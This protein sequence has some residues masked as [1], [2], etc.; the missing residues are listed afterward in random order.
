QPV[1]WG[2][3][4]ARKAY[5]GETKKDNERVAARIDLRVA[6]YG[7][8]AEAKFAALGRDKQ[9]QATRAEAEQFFGYNHR[10]YQQVLTALETTPRKEKFAAYQVKFNKDGRVALKPNKL[11]GT[12]VLE[13]LA[14][15]EKEPVPDRSYA[16]YLADLDQKAEEIRAATARVDKLVG[17][18]AKQTLLLNGVRA[19]DGKEVS[20]GYYQLL[21]R[22]AELQRK[23]RDEL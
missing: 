23:L 14:A 12:P 18:A 3:K 4:E 21:D 15:K 13:P 5:A 1:D 11:W 2:W 6:A 22:E 7:K 9:A 19:D 8:L 16:V 20:P 17:D 10:L